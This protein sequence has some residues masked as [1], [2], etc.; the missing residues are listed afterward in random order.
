MDDPVANN[1]FP[2]DLTL[3]GKEES[4]HKVPKMIVN[5]ENMEVWHYK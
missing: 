2:N 5:N 1:L 3:L 4:E